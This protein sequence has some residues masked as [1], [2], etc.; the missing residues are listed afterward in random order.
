MD[1]TGTEESGCQVDRPWT[2][3]CSAS[4][5]SVS[6]RTKTGCRVITFHTGVSSILSS[7]A[8]TLVAMSYVQMIRSLIIWA[9]L[10][11]CERSNTRKAEQDDLVCEDAAEQCV[12]VG[13]ERRVGPP[14]GHPPARLQHGGALRHR[15]RPRQA[16]PLHRALA[17]HGPAPTTLLRSGN[18][19]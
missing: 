2:I 1:G 10:D 9:S 17:A 3:F 18:P 5:A 6:E 16:Q 15:Q 8:I 13:E 4:T 12:G 14:C 7:R 11:D 19:N